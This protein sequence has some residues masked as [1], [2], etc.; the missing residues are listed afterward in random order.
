MAML[1]EL[2]FE[3]FDPPWFW[4][5]L[6]AASLVIVVLTYRGIWQRSGRKL[7]WLLL[8][9][10]IIGAAALLVALIKPVWL[11]NRRV[12]QRPQVAVIV[13]D[14][15]SMALP[16]ELSAPGNDA[17]GASAAAPPVLTRYE[18]AEQWLMQSDAGRA[19]RD[20]FDVQVSNIA[21]VRLAADR[22]A[23]EPNAEHTDLHRALAGVGDRLRGRLVAGVILISD[24]RDTSGRRADLSLDEYAH[25]VYTIGFRQPPPR[26]GGPV[27]VALVNV[28]APDRARVH[29]SALIKV[30]V[31]KDGGPAMQVPLTLERSGQTLAGA[32][33]E[34]GPGAAQATAAV[35]YTP[36][37]AGDFVLTVRAAAAPNERT[38]S[39]NHRTFAL[40]VEAE[41]IRVL[42][43]EGYLRPE[44]TFLRQRLSDDP[45]VDLITFVRSANPDQIATA[46]A[47]MDSELLSQERLAKMHVVMLG[48]FE[49]AMLDAR[50]YERLRDW[51]DEGGGLIVLGG[52]QNLGDAGL[53]DTAL[54]DVLPAEFERAAGQIDEPFGFEPSLEGARHPVLSI[55]GHM[56]RDREL[57]AKLPKL[58][59]IAAV[60]RAKPGATVLATHPQRRVDASGAGGPADE[61][62]NA[63]AADA[64]IVLAAHRF[65]QGHAALLTA[66]TTWRWSRIPR[67]AGRPD[68]LY[69]R[70]W[71]QMVRWLAQRDPK[72]QGPAL[73]VVT[74]AP[75]YDRGRRVTVHVRRNPSTIVPDDRQTP[76]GLSLTVNTP[77]RRTATL[78]PIAHAA[79]PNQWSAHY[80]PDRGG[81]FEVAARLSAAG[82]QIGGGERIGDEQAG[83]DL[84]NQVTEFIV[85][86]AGLEL[87]DPSTNPA[88]LTQIAQR[89]GGQYADID[90]EQAASEIIASLPR[91]PRINVE[92]KITHA[93][94]SPLLF[95][96][97]ILVLT[98]E[99]IVRRRN[100][101]V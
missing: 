67:L 41:P 5:L 63:S 94:N 37:R 13:D 57:W 46:G 42:Y 51:V 58:R 26:P 15:Q 96:F 82:A 101:L 44:Y 1:G 80:F 54:A 43:I 34:L 32:R 64:Y 65:G 88:A 53:G 95:I 45:D 35:E 25:A 59:G 60:G 83:G 52:Y 17:S 22:L 61:N 66:D 2:T 73:S 39:N 33:V 91:Q 19:L 86:G 93:W 100:Q 48:D 49:A 87:D 40:K 50:A 77:D 68:A 62:A 75:V 69:S 29:N 21:G 7:T 36:R 4:L 8:S 85:R 70:F 18:R 72:D 98:I 10:R 28:D 76:A 84:A 3:N 9:M 11:S 12:E 55:T 16:Y 90:D 30:L 99:W 24:G 71:S 79:D 92:A 81:R 27:D 47:L 97:F 14:S 56:Q 89:T 74:D 31:R 23:D 78:T 6:I 38:A 20:D